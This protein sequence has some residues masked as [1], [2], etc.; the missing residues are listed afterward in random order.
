MAFNP[1][2]TELNATGNPSLSDEEVVSRVRAGDTSLYE[3]LM[4]RYNQR[5][6]R[7]TRTILRDDH[8]AEDVMQEAYVRAYASLHQFAGRAKFST[9]L[10][11]IAIHEAFSRLRKRAREDPARAHRKS[12]SLEA[13]KTLDLNPEEQS[14]RHEARSLL[15]QA[16]DALPDLY[17]A[18]FVLREI[19]NMSPADTAQCLDLTEG[20]V[21]VRLHRARQMLRQDLYMRARVTSSQAFQFQGA[22]CD[23][24]VRRVLDDLA[25]ALLCPNSR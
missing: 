1:I 5:L 10:A 14:L 2:G 18:V 24:L 17:R 21:N 12:E 19:E 9:W 6:F 11:K 23:H 25:C 20:A 3:V 8:E 4:R 7:I 13:M 16:V 22:R 15:E